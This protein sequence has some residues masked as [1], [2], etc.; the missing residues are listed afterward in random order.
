M[1]RRAGPNIGPKTRQPALGPGGSPTHHELALDLIFNREALRTRLP[2]TLS[3]RWSGAPPP[4]TGTRSVIR[5]D[6]YIGSRRSRN[7]PCHTPFHYLCFRNCL[8]SQLTLIRLNLWHIP[9][10]EYLRPEAIVVGLAELANLKSLTIGFESPLSRPDQEFQR[11]PPPKRTVL[12]ALAR[13]ELKGVSEYAEDLVA[14]IDAPLLES[15]YATFFDQLVFDVPQLAQLMRHTT[16]CQALNEAHMDF[17][18]HRVQVEFLPPTRTLDE[19]SRLKVLCDGLNPHLS[20]LLQVFSSIF[21]SICSAEHLYIYTSRHTE[22]LQ[23]LE[24]L[25]PFTAVKNL[26]L[27]RKFAQRI[28]LALL[29]REDVLP[30]LPAFENLFLEQSQPWEPVRDFNNEW[31]PARHWAV[32]CCTKALRS[33]CDRFPMGRATYYSPFVDSR[34]QLQYLS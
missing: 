19:K 9:H 33:P 7:I 29:V 5:K 20:S 21:P 10:S 8:C 12:L 27:N 25:H 4:P 26:Y 30:H 28:A 14:Q 22:D 11:S 32:H 13:F 17:G 2:S 3:A 15:V 16:G 18:D 24:I 6:A 1:M 31:P 23:W 34:D